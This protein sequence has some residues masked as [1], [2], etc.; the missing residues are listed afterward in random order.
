MTF[1]LDNK[2]LDSRS[3]GKNQKIECHTTFYLHC[4]L[5]IKP[6]NVGSYDLAQITFRDEG[7]LNE[8]L[9]RDFLPALKAFTSLIPLRISLP[10]RA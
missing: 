5:H 6:A 2:D 3:E 9:R 1:H 4:K 10:Y 7:T 8:S